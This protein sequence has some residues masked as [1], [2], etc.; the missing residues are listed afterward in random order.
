M[1]DFIV[2]QK[3][4]GS[5]RAFLCPTNRAGNVTP[6]LWGGITL[7]NV[8]RTC[9]LHARLCESVFWFIITFGN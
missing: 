5:L 4:Q 8:I 2:R 9:L 3:T 1:T 6:A 7:K